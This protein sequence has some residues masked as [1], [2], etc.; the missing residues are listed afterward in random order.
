[1]RPG[2]S[3]AATAEISEKIERGR[4]T[5][6]RVEL[7][8]FLG[9]YIADTPGFGDVAYEDC[10]K[11]EKGALKHLFRE[12]GEYFGKCRFTDCV[13]INEPDC[14]VKE[15]VKEGKISK[16]R[17]EN[18]CLIYEECVLKPRR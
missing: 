7:F 3:V 9:G 14:A 6:K 10:L 2:W 15:A 5:T 8:D 12:F 18:Y 1:M 17:Y 13:H 4:H 11:A 16:A